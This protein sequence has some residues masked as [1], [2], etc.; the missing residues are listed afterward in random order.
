M[1]CIARVLVSPR[2]SDRPVEP[3]FTRR[4]CTNLHE[5][6]SLVDGKIENPRELIEVGAGVAIRRKDERKTRT[7]IVLLSR[8]LTLAVYVNFT[9]A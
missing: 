6:P 3:P 1:G 5:S 8:S 9:A 4:A 7:R 2:A